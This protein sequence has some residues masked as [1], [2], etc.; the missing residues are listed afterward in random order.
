MAT[1]WGNYL[2]FPFQVIETLGAGTEWHTDHITS[3]GAE[4]FNSRWDDSRWHFSLSGAKV[5]ST[6]IETWDAFVE[7][8]RGAYEPFLFRANSR[9][10][11]LNNAVIGHGDGT[12]KTFQLKKT[13]S[14]QGRDSVEVV[15]F[16]WH[17]YP[18]IMLATGQKA[19][20]TGYVQ[21]S[22]GGVAKTNGTDYTVD[23]ETGIVTFGTAPTAT[24]SPAITATCKY[25]KLVHGIDLNI[26]DSGGGDSWT[27]SQSSELIG[28]FDE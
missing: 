22:V 7:A 5:L 3:I 13:R 26:L 23:R 4:V 15:K 14:I 25:M 27:F 2:I 16:P 28:V 12:T 9:R 11:E 19:L 17:N 8:S 24:G 18:D 20:K 10:F 1:S 21:I 6:E